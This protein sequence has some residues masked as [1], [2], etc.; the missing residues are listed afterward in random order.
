MQRSRSSSLSEEHVAPPSVT[1]MIAVVDHPIKTLMSD[2]MNV[3]EPSQIENQP[4][5]VVCN[6]TS[7]DKASDNDLEEASFNTLGLLYNGDTV[8]PHACIFLTNDWTVPERII[9]VVV[10]AKPESLQRAM[11]RAKEQHRQSRKKLKA[12]KVS[13]IVF[14]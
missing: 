8:H 6:S 13:C 10:P 1:E 3:C 11:K 12:V 7:E 14:E 5:D 2:G 9:P 4:C